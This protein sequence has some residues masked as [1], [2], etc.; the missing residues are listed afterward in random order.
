VAVFAV[1]FLVLF[2]GL[3]V[4]VEGRDFSFIMG[5]VELICFSLQAIFGEVWFALVVGWSIRGGTSLGQL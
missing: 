4:F 5:G 1:L 3:L 2:L